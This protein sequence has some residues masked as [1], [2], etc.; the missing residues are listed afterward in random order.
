MLVFLVKE[1][2]QKYKSEKSRSKNSQEVSCCRKT[3]ESGLMK[4]VFYLEELS[5]RINFQSHAKY[6]ADFDT[7]DKDTATNHLLQNFQNV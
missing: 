1:F 5:A 4:G 7:L 2:N 6:L 3:S